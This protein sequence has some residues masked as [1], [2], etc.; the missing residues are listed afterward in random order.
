MLLSQRVLVAY[1]CWVRV[2]PNKGDR[3][4]SVFEIVKVSQGLP[5]FVLGLNQSSWP[6]GAHESDSVFG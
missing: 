4:V 2:V 5:V 3:G 1:Q 6:L